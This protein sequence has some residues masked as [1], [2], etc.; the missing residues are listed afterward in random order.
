VV[1]LLHVAI[2]FDGIAQFVWQQILSTQCPFVHSILPLQGEPSTF[3]PHVPFVHVL[4]G[5][6]SLPDGVQLE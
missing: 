2:P 3:R 5:P 6:H 1:P 4:P